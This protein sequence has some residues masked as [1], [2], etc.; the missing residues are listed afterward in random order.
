MDMT[1]RERVERLLKHERID[2]IPIYPFGGS[3]SMVYSGCTLAELFNN[4]ALSF[5]SQ[6]KAAEDF[7]WVFVPDLAY[8]AFGGWEFGGAIRW[9]DQE[10]DQ[11]PTIT[12]YPAKTPEDVMKL[13]IP[14]I[15][16]AGIIPLQKQFFDLSLQSKD[17]NKP[18]DVVG[19]LEGTFTMASNIVGAELFTKWVMKQ[20]E[21]VHRLMR[22][23]ADFE[24]KMAEYWKSIYGTIGVIL[25]G[26]EP[27]ASNQ[28]ISPK[29]FKKFVLPYRKEVHEKVLDLG[30]QTIFMH[31]CGEQ[32]G[33]LPFWAQ[34]PMG[35]PG[36]LSFGHEVD[37]IKAAE[38][39]PD[40]II[41]GNLDPSIVQ[42]GT[43]KEVYEASRIVIETGKWIK[44]G[45]M[46]GPGCELPPRA[47]VE[48]VR[49]MTEAVQ[50][51]GVYA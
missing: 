34:V 49:A 3:F 48:N 20:P 38:Y 24:I 27:V 28:V 19:Q 43:P 40:E 41:V 42:V 37:L 1:N 6:R 18:W 25:W 8:A 2:R 11:A 15:S 31:I 9:P 47:P 45:F 5:E 21:I 4:P 13:E 50:D 14:E 30:F 22:L 35:S 12:R 39:F 44:G 46:F 32:N 7:D 51:F 33:N 17:E 26:G 36:I 10:F 16:S 23:A 29:T